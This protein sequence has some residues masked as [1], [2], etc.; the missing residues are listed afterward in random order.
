MGK[1][2]I[3][4]RVREVAQETADKLGF[5]LVHIENKGLGTGRV[6]RVF[7]EKE[8]GIS[9]EDCS[10][11]SNDFGEILDSEDLVHA[12]YILEVSSPGL[13]REL[14]SLRD[15]VRFAG[16]PAKIRTR[17]AIA[18]QKNFRGRIEKVSDETIVFEDRTSGRVEISFDN[19]VKANLE[20]DV[21]AELKRSK[22]DRK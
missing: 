9:V 7:I 1:S 22:A 21:E 15:F 6:L 4:D 13:E 17:Q 18:G 16:N 3:S 19:V 2:L 11:F 20:F 12:E 5:E 10:R 14:Y 8:A